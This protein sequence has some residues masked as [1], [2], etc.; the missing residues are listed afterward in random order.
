MV[1]AHVGPL[2]FEICYLIYRIYNL[3]ALDS[4]VNLGRVIRSEK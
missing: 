3:I 4:F 2:V 1:R